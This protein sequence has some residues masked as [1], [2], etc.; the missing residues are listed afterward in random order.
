MI[1]I[2]MQIAR[3]LKRFDAVQVNKRGGRSCK[4]DEGNLITHIKKWKRS[5]LLVAGI[6]C[7]NKPPRLFRL[8]LDIPCYDNRNFN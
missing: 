2:D 3:G 8:L 6:S 7:Q 1:K 5:S 4:R